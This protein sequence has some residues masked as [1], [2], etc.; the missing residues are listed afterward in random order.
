[1][2]RPKFISFSNHYGMFLHKNYLNNL[3][4]FKEESTTI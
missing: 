3:M 4:Y 1:M 2:R